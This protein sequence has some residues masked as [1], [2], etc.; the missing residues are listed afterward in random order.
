[1]R[2]LAAS[3]GQSALAT[4]PVLSY[5]C[6]KNNAHGADYGSSREER[7]VQADYI[8][9]AGVL[10]TAVGSLVTWLVAKRQFA[11]KKLTYSYTIEKIV[12]SADP[13]LARDLKVFYRNELLPEPTLMNLEITNTGRTAIEDARVV[14]QLPGATYLIPGH[15]VDLPTGYLM[16]WD[17]ERTDA[18][19]C[20]VRFN[21]INPRQTAK[22][23]LLMDEMPN[24]EPSIACPMPNVECTKAS[25]ATMGVVAEAIVAVVAPQILGMAR[26]R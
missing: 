23:R 24:G 14:I 10:A 7:L 17:L 1:M 13:D 8:A 11:S 9:I 20:T 18:E 25:I 22:I 26:L 2:F 12:K 21:H 15:F 5:L 6:M 19:E 16:L 3:Y 4:V